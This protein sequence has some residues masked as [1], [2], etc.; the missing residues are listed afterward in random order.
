VKWGCF[1][2]IEDWL[3]SSLLRSGSRFRDCFPHGRSSPK[4]PTTLKESPISAPQGQGPFGPSSSS[5]FGIQPVRPTRRRGKAE[6][7]AIVAPDRMNQES[8]NRTDGTCP[9]PLI[10]KGTQD[11]R[12]L[13]ESCVSLDHRA[14]AR[15]Q[16]KRE[17]CTQNSTDLI[18]RLHSKSPDFSRIAPDWFANGRRG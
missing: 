6:I 7:L 4:R 17:R 14:V 11:G 13:R 18:R 10:V 12:K 2:N 15:Y 3:P 16:S 1:V 9:M 8:R 5:L